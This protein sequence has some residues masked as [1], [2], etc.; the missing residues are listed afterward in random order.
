MTD[1]LLLPLAPSVL[2]KSQLD[3]LKSRKDVKC[4]YVTSGR[5]DMMTLMWFSST[6]QAYKF[7][8]EDVVKLEGV[9]VIEKKE[10]I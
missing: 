3:A 8:E 4:L 2:A 1:P 7:M 5:Y 6:E 9:K 10:A